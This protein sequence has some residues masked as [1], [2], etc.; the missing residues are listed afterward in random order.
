MIDTLYASTAIFGG[1]VGLIISS[2]IFIDGCASLSRLLG[3]STTMIGLT[4]VAFGT[5]APEIVVSIESARDGVPGL[6][7]GNAIGSN[8]ANIGLV[9]GIT[10]II[11]SMKTNNNLLVIN[12]INPIYKSRLG[13]AIWL[14]IVTFVAAFL[15]SNQILSTLD[16]IILILLAIL[17]SIITMRDAKSDSN[18][19]DNIE[20]NFNLSKISTA[21]AVSYFL[22]G[23]ALLIVSANILINGAVSLAR[24]FNVDEMIIGLTLIALGTSLPELAAC[25]SSV[26]KGYHGIALGNIIGSNIL[27]LLTVMA[28]PGLFSPVIFEKTIVSRDIPVL[29]FLTIALIIFIYSIS[30][31]DQ[32]KQ[33]IN[34]SRLL[35]LCFLSIY[36]FYNILIFVN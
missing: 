2:N 31:N 16:S 18:I 11:T 36:A 20:T 3:M 27:N 33:G 7:I 14:L 8:I 32:K 12:I 28:I 30:S 25:I 15:L 5:S 17:I 1:L 4:V 26:L 34:F 23:L 6:A 29:I 19:I 22:V 9:L 21:Q 13:Q 10:A 35:G 24:Q